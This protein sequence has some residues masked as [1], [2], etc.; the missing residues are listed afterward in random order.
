MKVVGCQPSA[1]AAFTPQEI[2]LVLSSVRGW[3]DPRAIMRPTG[4]C[5]WKKST[6]T[7]GNRT[8]DLPVCRAVPQPTAPPR[9]LSVPGQVQIVRNKLIHGYTVSLPLVWNVP[10]KWKASHSI[11]L[12]PWNTTRQESRLVR[13]SC[14]TAYARHTAALKTRWCETFDENYYQKHDHSTT[15]RQNIPFHHSR[16]KYHSQL[17]F[18]STGTPRLLPWRNYRLSVA[19]ND[20]SN[21]V[22]EVR[23]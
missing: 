7:I 20:T 10:E 12:R 15:L 17:T 5:Q 8:R 23:K 13:R 11:R 18:K 1:P 6:D 4:L 14:P 16:I 2:F 9:P 22:C 21:A 3:V 19:R